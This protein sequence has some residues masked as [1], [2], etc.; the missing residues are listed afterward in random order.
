MKKINTMVRHVFFPP[1]CICN[2]V[3]VKHFF[4]GI[5][6]IVILSFFLKFFFQSI[7]FVALYTY[8]CY[9][10]LYLWHF[11]NVLL[12]FLFRN[13]EYIKSDMCFDIDWSQ[14]RPKKYWIWYWRWK[15]CLSL[16]KTNGM[17]WETSV[18]DWELVLGKGRNWSRTTSVSLKNY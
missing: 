3:V 4:K 17:Q 7:L 10:H 5:V 9:I 15:L 11:T 2:Q 16:M 8:K 6:I 1:E 18:Y 14:Y 13:N 12:F